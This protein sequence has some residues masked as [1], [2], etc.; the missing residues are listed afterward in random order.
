MT[1][2]FAEL[3]LQVI[4]SGCGI[5]PEIVGKI[6]DPFFT[7]KPQGK[8]TGLGLSISHGIVTD[9]GGRITVESA[10]A[11]GACFTVYLPSRGPAATAAAR[12]TA[13]A[14]PPPI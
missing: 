7:T 6:F 14:P 4:D 1:V 13:E 11:K 5:D 2:T 3:E 9:H 8:G 12:A 10:P